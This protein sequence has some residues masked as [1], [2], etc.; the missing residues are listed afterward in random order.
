MGAIRGGHL[1]LQGLMLGASFCFYSQVRKSK[2]A[3]CMMEHFGSR[4][5]AG[6]NYQKLDE[7]APRNIH[8]DS[9]CSKTFFLDELKT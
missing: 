5:Y 3:C 4:D 1:K 8:L 6:I 9:Q 7:P 2:T